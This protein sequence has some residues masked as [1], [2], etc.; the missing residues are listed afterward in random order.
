MELCKR[1]AKASAILLA[2]FGVA[3]TGRQSM[4]SEW[5]DDERIYQDMNRATTSAEA[6]RANRLIEAWANATG[7]ETTR[8]VFIA[9]MQIIHTMGPAYCEI[10]AT[11]LALASRWMDDDASEGTPF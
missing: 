7:K 11:N 3:N 1:L 2:F 5:H 9:C 4:T 8:I 10:A 6:M